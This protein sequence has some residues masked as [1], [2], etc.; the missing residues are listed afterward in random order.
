MAD[1]TLWLLFS[2]VLAILE[3]LTPTFF[4]LWFSIG[5]LAACISSVFIVHDFVNV[6]VFLTVSILL[7]LSTRK[8]V[9]K[10]SKV[11]SPKTLYQDDIQGKTAKIKSVSDDGSFIVTVL[12]EEWKA[13]A[14]NSSEKQELT[15]GSIVKV[16]KRE[17]NILYIQRL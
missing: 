1:W 2:V 6:T 16:I 11:E 9:K 7:W 14:S 10:L 12:G 15:C 4:L 8:I 5:A 17:S 3:L 13:L